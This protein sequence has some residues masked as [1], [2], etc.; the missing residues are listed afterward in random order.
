MKITDRNHNHDHSTTANTTL[1]SIGVKRSHRKNK[2]HNNILL[3]LLS[4]LTY[5]A[6]S[7]SSFLL[8][9]LIVAAILFGLWNIYKCH[10]WIHRSHNN[11]GDV[12]GSMISKI[13][14]NSTSRTRNGTITVIINETNPVSPVSNNNNNNDYK[15]EV[16]IVT[17]IHG[18]HQ[19]GL[20]EQSQCLFHHAYNNE[21]LYDVVVF[22]T[23]PIPGSNIQSLQNLLSSSVVN[24]NL[25][26]VVDNLGSLQKEIDALPVKQK[27]TFHR[28]CIDEYYR[29]RNNS[30]NSNNTN[31]SASITAIDVDDDD[32]DDDDDTIIQNLTWFSDC[33]DGRLAYNWQSEFRSRRLWTHPS[34]IKY[35]YMVWIDSDV[36]AT[37]IIPSKSKSKDNDDDPVQIVIKNDLVLLFDNFPQ[38]FTRKLGERISDGFLFDDDN[39][40]DN[41]NKRVRIKAKQ[42]KKHKKRLCRLRLT[43]EGIFESTFEN[44]ATT[45]EQVND[46][47]NNNNRTTKSN[48]SSSS[49]NN[50]CDWN[51]TR[52]GGVHGFFHITDLNF[53]RQPKV[54]HGINTLFGDCFLCR[55]PDDQ[56]AVSIPAAMYQPS[57]SWDIQ[58]IP[59]SDISLGL[60]HNYRL[61]G[62]NENKTGM[63]FKQ[64]W[65]TKKLR[66]GMKGARGVCPVTEKG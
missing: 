9:F 26:V 17:K 24:V 4:A 60:Y 50:D 37:K 27:T 66:Q 15:A 59:Y 51:N 14:K 46:G 2:N 48:S 47:E 32:D 44:V 64:L 39:D 49:N 33:G 52:I 1:T 42:R 30:N 7:S 20:L 21:T 38:G 10:I 61:D 43:P 25:N 8:F 41:D 31:T 55:F 3:R 12:I 54:L 23:E 11:N 22:T 36:F 58:K 13:S 40:N 62:K 28:K 5:P 65:R 29:R 56:L 35:R 63:G 34:I 53:Y 16:V 57:K 45:T 18:I 19:W 6:S